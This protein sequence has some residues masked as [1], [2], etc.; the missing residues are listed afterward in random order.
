MGGSNPVGVSQGNSP[1]GPDPLS[2]SLAAVSKANPDTV[3][4]TAPTKFGKLAK[5]MVPLLVGGGVGALVGGATGKSTYGGGFAGAQNF[6]AQQHQRQLQN[7]MIQRL[8]ANDQ[9]HNALLTQQ[10]QLDAAR[11]QHEIA[12]PN[13][14]GRATAPQ[15]MTNAQG[16]QVMGRVNPIS[17]EVEEIPDFTPPAAK[18]T[19][20]F[21]LHD[22]DQGVVKMDRR[23]GKITPATIDDG[24]DD[25]EQSSQGV[26][27]LSRV[28]SRF[29]SGSPQAPGSGKAPSTVPGGK[30]LTKSKQGRNESVDE[31]TFDSLVEGGMTPDQARAHLKQQNRLSQKPDKPEKD[32]DAPLVGDRYRKVQTHYNDQ[33]NREL[34]ASEAQRT[35]DIAASKKA[36]GELTDEESERIEE[37]NNNR[38]QSIHQRIAD[39]AGGQG[40][41]LGTVPDYSNQK[42]GGKASRNAPGA[43]ADDSEAAPTKTP[44]AKTVT[45]EIVSAWAKKK[46]ITLDAARKQFE[47]KKYTIQGGA[48]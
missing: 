41:N 6:F 18:D 5:L 48:Q 43:T 27:R 14:T 3:S 9:F 21:E 42:A 35:R 20:S 17:G 28:P 38:K 47:A 8:A 26:G 10:A 12:R 29:D 34:Q 33:L 4:V 31:Q 40:V 32:P 22:T 7:T 46:N 37:E 23:K 44:A 11:T 13:F 30:Q 19:D 45:P 16:K 1:S 15:P 25:A 2:Q 24:T 39:E 36:N